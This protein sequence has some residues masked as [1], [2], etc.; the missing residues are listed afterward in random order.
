MAMTLESYVF[1]IPVFLE[2]YESKRN[3]SS[4]EENKVQISFEN[5]PR[6]VWYFLLLLAWEMCGTFRMLLRL[7]HKIPPSV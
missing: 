1:S 4:T 3:M 5:S 6:N 2:Y 7:P